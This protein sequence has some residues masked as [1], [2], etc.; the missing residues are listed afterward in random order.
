MSKKAKSHTTSFILE[1]EFLG[2]VW[3]DKKCKFIQ[4]ATPEKELTLSISKQGKRKKKGNKN[5]KKR[6]LE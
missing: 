5:A 1:G 3:H 2:F 6:K 4:I